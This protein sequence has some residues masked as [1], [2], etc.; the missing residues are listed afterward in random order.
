MVTENLVKMPEL[1]NLKL[2]LSKFIKNFVIKIL[3]SS[4]NNIIVIL[5][6]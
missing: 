2:N 5:W 3:I 6:G 1:T 4:Y